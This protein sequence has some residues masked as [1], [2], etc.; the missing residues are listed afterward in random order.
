MSMDE[1]ADLL[2]RIERSAFR[3]ETLDTYSAPGEQ[4]LLRTFRSGRPM[5]RRHPDTEPWLRMTA[6]SVAAGRRWSRVHLVTRPLSEYMQFALLGYQGNV[7]AGEDVRVADRT[8]ADPVLDALTTDFWLL[9]DN[10]ALVMTYT[11]AGRLADMTPAGDVEPYLQQRDI[12]MA[13]SVPLLEYLPSVR[14][15]LHRSW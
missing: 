1:L 14:H 2:R 7:A 13:H 6:D 12:A 5:P 4:E 11:E 9:D 10:L 8:V 3:L 15:E